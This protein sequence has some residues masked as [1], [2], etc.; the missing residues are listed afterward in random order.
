[1][2][3][4]KHFL[5]IWS[6]KVKANRLGLSMKLYCL[7]MQSFVIVEENISYTCVTIVFDLSSLLELWYY[8][9]THHHHQQQQQQDA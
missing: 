3:A 6:R 1:M 5:Q 2:F 8:T 4:W 9:H 7:L